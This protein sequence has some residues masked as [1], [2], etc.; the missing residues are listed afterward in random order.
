MVSP[1]EI[2]GFFLIKYE[3]GRF[4][5]SLIFFIYLFFLFLKILF[6]QFLYTVHLNYFLLRLFQRISSPKNE[7]LLYLL[8]VRP[9]KM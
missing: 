8:T 9:S 6:V 5:Y 2:I 4:V 3:I 1:G 7:N